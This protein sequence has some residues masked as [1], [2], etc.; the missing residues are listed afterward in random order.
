MKTKAIALEIIVAL[1]V[2][3]WIY[4]ALSK[5]ADYERF[6]IQ[7]QHSPIY[8]KFAGIIFYAVPLI[9]I[10]IA[11]M[12]VFA[13]TRKTGL[14]LS[15]GLLSVFTLYIMYV[16]TFAPYVP[17]SCGGVISSFSWLGHLF[18]NFGF[19]VLNTIGIYLYIENTRRTL[20]P[21]VG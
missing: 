11:L 2:F 19:L 7:L 17:C 9:E 1:L 14:Y 21:G 20:S 15:A 10:A 18:F 16:L 5:W 4:A 13:A 12:L 3:L 8:G 6:M